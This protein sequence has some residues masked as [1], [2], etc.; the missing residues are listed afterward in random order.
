VSLGLE[1]ATNT[2]DLGGH[3]TRDGRV[4]RSGLIFRSN[5]LNRL[6]DADVDAVGK[7]GL[8][9]VIDFRH[10]REIE[11]IGPDRLPSPS[12]RLVSLPLFDPDHDVFTAVSAVL[13]G[14]AGAEAIA[15]LHADAASGGAAVMM[16]DLYRRFVHEPR[17]RAVFATAMHLVA[18]P[19]AAVSLHGGQGPY[20]MARRHLAYGARRRPGHGGGG[21]SPHGRAQRGRQTA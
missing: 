5:A 1:K 16:V 19:G 13:K 10:R 3:R 6:S 14:D 17:S 18:T 2:R 4:V 20:R 9:C 7:L 12:P 21:L 15:H 11:L 8:A